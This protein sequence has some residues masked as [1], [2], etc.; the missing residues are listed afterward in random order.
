MGGNNRQQKKSSSRFSFFNIFKAKRSSK[1]VEDN[2]W[3]DSVRYYKVWPSD[4]DRGRYVA[5]PDIDRK[6]TIFIDK[7]RTQYVAEHDSQ[8]SN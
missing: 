4:E 2:S 8:A 1:V 6:A 7:I 5:E 3:D